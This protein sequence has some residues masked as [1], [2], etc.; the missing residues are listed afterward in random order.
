MLLARALHAST[1]DANV[2]RHDLDL[3]YHDEGPHG[4]DE[5]LLVGLP[6]SPRYGG[7][8]S[9]TFASADLKTGDGAPAG[10]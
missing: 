4:L 9:D 6:P 10:E 2:P 7:H 3:L 8:S 5:R 1:A